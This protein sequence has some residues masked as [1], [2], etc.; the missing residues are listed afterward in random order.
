MLD[1]ILGGGMSSRSLWIREK[2]ALAYTVGPPMWIASR[3]SGG[4]IVFAVGGDQFGQ[5]GEQARL[6]QAVAVDTVVTRLRP[7][8][9]EVAERGLLLFV[10]GKGITGD[11]KGRWLAH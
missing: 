1:G 9:I 6:C 5:C 4:F 2:R 3:I 11:R 10:I 7:G 8:F